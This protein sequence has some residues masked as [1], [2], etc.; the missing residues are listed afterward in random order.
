MKAQK[1]NDILKVY[2]VA[3]PSTD[4]F[5]AAFLASG[6]EDAARKY[7]EQLA[8]TGKLED[9]GLYL[10]VKEDRDGAEWVTFWAETHCK[11]DITTQEVVEDVRQ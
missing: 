3:E 8:C 6:H 5:Q 2:E 11:W 9:G 10:F 4:Y 1:H 7:I